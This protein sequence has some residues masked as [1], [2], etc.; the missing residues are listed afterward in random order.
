MDNKSLLDAMREAIDHELRASMHEILKDYPADYAAM[1]SYQLGWEG[2]K[3]KPSIQ[4]KRI[5]P[6]LVL[7]SCQAAGGDWHKALPA[8][9]SVELV[10]NFSLIHDDIQ[11]CSE[12]R[13][14]RPTI[15]VKWGNALAINAGDAM[16]TLAHLTLL[17]L[18][19]FYNDSTVLRAKEMLQIACLKL[20][21]GQYLDIAFED[22]EDLPMDLYWQM[23]E[24]K[25]GSLLATCLSMGA[26]LGG[27]ENRSVRSL[28][29]TGIKIGHAFQVQDDWLGI[30]G[31]DEETGKSCT[32]DL[33][34]RKKTYPVLLGIQK[35]KAFN[36]A[37]NEKKEINADR[38]RRLA[39]LLEEEGYDKATKEKFEEL[40]SEGF[41]E[42]EALPFSKENARPLKDVLQNLFGRIK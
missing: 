32:S 34:S 5:R 11:D 26:Y 17:R 4:G 35:N 24:G 23:V 10:H 20:T 12:L 16:L 42:L 38:A 8:A 21:R 2:G 22:K 14:G 7:L 37:W 25:T 29:N 33:I 30:W 1:L 27:A 15:W 3:N 39:R 18:S 13:R 41:S 31:D 28:F 36:A 40:Y 9:A 6:L 19:A